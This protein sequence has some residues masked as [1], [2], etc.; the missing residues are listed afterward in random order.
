MSWQDFLSKAERWIEEREDSGLVDRVISVS[1][2]AIGVPVDIV[3][4]NPEKILGWAG[5]KA[6]GVLTK[7]KEKMKNDE[8]DDHPERDSRGGEVLLH[9]RVPRGF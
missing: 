2:K 1:E 5:T 8:D 7:I 3:A 9:S 4:R 6:Q